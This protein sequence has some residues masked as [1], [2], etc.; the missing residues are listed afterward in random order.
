[1]ARQVE[2]VDT[3]LKHREALQYRMLLLILTVTTRV[4]RYGNRVARHGLRGRR[5]VSR[6]EAHLVCVDCVRG[7]NDQQER[8]RESVGDN[9]RHQRQNATVHG[10]REKFV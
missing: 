9:S 5:D 4:Y 8:H 3:C 10:T 2:S 6:P 1:M 7:R